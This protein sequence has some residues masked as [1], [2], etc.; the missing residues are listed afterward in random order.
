MDIKIIFAALK[1]PFFNLKPL[2]YV[3]NSFLRRNNPAHT[4]R[5]RRS[6]PCKT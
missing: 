3:N 2:T 5:T 4:H 6:W 1:P